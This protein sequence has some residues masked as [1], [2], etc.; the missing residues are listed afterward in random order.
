MENEVRARLATI[1]GRLRLAELAA[2]QQRALAELERSVGGHLRAPE[3]QQAEE[4][5]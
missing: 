4:R 3:A 2:E 5:P 1:E